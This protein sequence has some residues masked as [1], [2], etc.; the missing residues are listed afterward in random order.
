MGIAP[1]GSA[2]ALTLTV[3]CPQCGSTLRPDITWFGDS[4]DEDVF[5]RARA[6]IDACDLFVSIGI[7]FLAFG[8]VIRIGQ[9]RSSGSYDFYIAQEQ[10]KPPRVCFDS[11]FQELAE[12]IPSGAEVDLEPLGD[13]QRLQIQMGD[14]LTI[15]TRP[16]ASGQKK[17]D[18]DH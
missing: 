6:L 10:Q 17:S 11:G 7:A 16:A 15:S 3:R 5:D 12:I 18:P 2:T 13:L 4:V 1:P 8:I 14:R 9:N